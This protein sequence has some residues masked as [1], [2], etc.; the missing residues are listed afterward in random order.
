MPPVKIC[1]IDT[2]EQKMVGSVG[3]KLYKQIEGFSQEQLYLYG[4][5][6]DCV[7]T[8]SLREDSYEYKKYGETITVC[9][10]Y[11]REERKALE[12]NPSALNEQPCVKAKLLVCHEK[13]CENAVK[14][15]M[16]VE[17]RTK[18]IVD[19]IVAPPIQ[20][21]N[22]FPSKEKRTLNIMEIPFTALGKGRDIVWMY[23]FLKLLK[24]KGIG[25][26]PEDEAQYLAYKIIIEPELLS[27][28]EKEEAFDKEGMMNSTVMFHILLWK[29]DA[30]IITEEEKI[31]LGELKKERFEERMTLLKSCLKNLGM[32]L[33]KLLQEYP[34]QAKLILEKVITFRDKNFNVSGKYPLYMNFESLLHIYFRHTDEMN[35][36]PQFANRDK[37]QL[38]ERDILSVIG[39]VMRALNDEYQAFKTN[40]P[41]GRFFRSGKMA[42][43]LN[44]DYYHVNVN[45]NGCVSTFYKGKGKKLKRMLD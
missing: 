36:C 28:E 13:R 23:G 7:F 45:A 10:I 30:E 33:T 34:Q 2:I 8:L 39:I 9:F 11:T 42:Y 15:I 32:S 14:E 41:E 44:G 40:N 37:F 24:E 5:R 22:T 17:I 27:A 4:G 43:Y 12:N 19:I 25:L 16:K 6:L 1:M 3:M 35:I 26:M 20:R 18:D 31:N 29:Q 38:E 21:N